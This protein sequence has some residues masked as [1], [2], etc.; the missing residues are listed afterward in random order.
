MG[1]SMV[2]IARGE[3]SIVNPGPGKELAPG[4]QVLVLGT[5]VQQEMALRTL[6]TKL[7]N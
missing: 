3:Q 1:A 2:G 7:A 5:E 6:R 4:D